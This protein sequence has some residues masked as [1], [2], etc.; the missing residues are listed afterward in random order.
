MT[1]K[2]NASDVIKAQQFKKEMSVE[3]FS[4]TDEFKTLE[5][6]GLMSIEPNK[7]YKKAVNTL[8]LNLKK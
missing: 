4:K 6:A 5:Q 2:I 1:I 7:V 8:R 3:E